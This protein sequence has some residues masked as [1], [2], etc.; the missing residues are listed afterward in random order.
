MCPHDKKL[1]ENLLNILP[2]NSGSIEFLRTF[3]FKSYH[4]AS[5]TLN[6]L[7]RFHYLWNGVEYNFV[8]DE[9]NELLN[10]LK[11]KTKKFLLN[12]DMNVYPAEAYG[13]KKVLRE[14][15]NGERNEEYNKII[16]ELHNDSGEI[17][18]AR[19]EIIKLFIEKDND[20]KIT[21]DKECTF[22]QAITYFIKDLYSATPCQDSI[23]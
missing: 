16:E 2:T 17:I 13:F 22:K 21:S 5:D 8:D 9:L 14:F 6:D 4:F 15:N 19:E 11:D 3:D 20:N 18:K 7:E 1:Y 10:Q 12:V 23:S